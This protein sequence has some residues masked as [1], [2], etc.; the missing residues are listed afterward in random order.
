MRLSSSIDM[1]VLSTV[2]KKSEVEI[3]FN[4]Y[5][6]N[7]ISEYWQGYGV[8]AY[9]HNFNIK[10]GD[11]SLYVGIQHNMK[12]SIQG[13][14]DMVAKYNP[15]KVFGV[16]LASVICQFFIGNPFTKV[17][18][19]D[20]AIDIPIN[21]L[22]VFPQPEGKMSKRVI[23]N[24]GDNKT[25]YFK[26]RGSNGA[27]KIY[28]KKREACLDYELTRYEM[29]LNPNISIDGMCF[30]EL[31][32]RLLIPLYISGDVQLGFEVKGTD[33]VLLL[34]CLEHFEYLDELPRKKKAKIKEFIE[35][36]LCQVEINVEPL[37]N[38]INSYFNNMLS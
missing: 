29:T 10:I 5:R 17:K 33:K 38:V 13:S 11:S 2:A 34:A 8:K 37:N 7:P 23:D 1:V 6:D 27:I 21:I 26:E 32:E 35:N 28:N 3:Y 31:D 16:E 22:S 19:F 20:L 25:Y 30:Y 15:N 12:K 18:S 9:K 4:R 14:V 24:G 36:L